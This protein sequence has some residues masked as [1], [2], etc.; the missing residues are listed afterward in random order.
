MAGS[1]SRRPVVVGVVLLLVLLAVAAVEGAGFA[2]TGLPRATENRAVVVI[3]DG[4]TRR[5]ACILFTGTIDGIEALERAGADTVLAGFGGMGAAVCSIDGVGCSAS[6][7]LTCQ[8]PDHWTYLRAAAGSSMLTAAPL[9]ASSSKLGD[10]DVEAWV[11]GTTVAPR[12]APSVDDVCPARTPTT[13]ARIPP[14]TKPPTPTAPP[15]EPRPTNDPPTRPGDAEVPV[16]S[17][18]S[19]GPGPAV[20]LP[21]PIVATTTIG[22]GPDTTRDARPTTTTDALADRAAVD[23]STSRPRADE[24]RRDPADERSV[25][26]PEERAAGAPPSGPSPDEATSPSLGLLA[27]AGVVAALGAWAMVLR[28]RAAG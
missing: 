9:G 22:G 28:H 7:C 8:A 6:A 26:G 24:G 2:D 12:P 10:G 15:T 18:T 11:W 20:A 1:P 23:T 21:P 14:T 3:D 25:A 27:V 17:V 19:I 5:E 13:T 16:T 4:V